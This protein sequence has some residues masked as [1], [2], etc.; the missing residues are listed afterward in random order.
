M[1]MLVVRLP[2]IYALALTLALAAI[3]TQTMRAQSAAGQP[4]FDCSNAQARVSQLNSGLPVMEEALKRSE[5]RMDSLQREL[6]LGKEEAQKQETEL[7]QEQM[8]EAA[9][10]ALDELVPL[11]AR[12]KAF[13]A[14]GQ[15]AG[16]SPSTSTDFLRQMNAINEQL[17][18]IETLSKLLTGF[19]AGMT[20]GQ[21]IQGSAHSLGEHISMLNTML[22][23]S[24]FYNQAG[25]A[26]A[27]SLLGPAGP[28]V[29]N[30]VLSLID[31]SLQSEAN[32]DLVVQE[33][34]EADTENTL[35]RSVDNV[36]DQIQEL[37]T[38]CLNQT[39]SSSVPNS[40]PPVPPPA[41]PPP[42]GADSH[43]GAIIL[44]GVLAVGGVAAYAAG[45][46]MKNADDATSSGGGSGQCNGLSPRNACGTCTSNDSASEC[47]ESDDCWTGGGRAPFC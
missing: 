4:I 46:A 29:F 25:N 28:M 16:I 39:A 21:Q 9:S 37:Q 8:K 17:S 10:E 47:G 11:R 1:K 7:A 23:N 33:Q 42:P 18:Q 40:P 22:T 15:A 3:G 32:F 20:Y 36:H 24:G 43:A 5:A 14:A 27:G 38:N 2:G 6:K 41:S 19:Q 13:Q 26:L 12:L 30:R 34:Q 31:T 44:V 45:V 35:R